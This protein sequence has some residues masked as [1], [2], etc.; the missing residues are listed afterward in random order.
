MAASTWEDEEDHGPVLIPPGLYDLAYV[1]HQT[2]RIFGAEKLYIDFR[3]VTEGPHF[4]VKLSRYYGVTIYGKAR[5]N[6]RFAA[7]WLSDCMYEHVKL[8]RSR[9]R[10]PSEIPMR[11]YQQHI[12]Q[13]RVA[14]VRTNRAQKEFPELL[15]YS[16]ISEL[17][18][19]V[20]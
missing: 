2:K 12:I 5:K 4:G 19:T 11:P 20:S 17:I 7:G 3:V 15:H 14:T 1:K 10:R 16:K 6:G 9:P 13:G 18:K 8:F